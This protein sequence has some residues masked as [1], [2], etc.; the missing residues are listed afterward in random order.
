[1]SLFLKKLQKNWAEGRYFCV[2][3]DTDAARLDLGVD[4]YEFNRKIIDQ[5]WDLV[6]AYKPNSAF[7]EAAGVA[8]YKA[9]QKTIQYI[10]EKAPEVLVIL[11]AK[12]GDIGNTSQAYARAAFEELQ[13][14]AVTLSPYMGQTSLQPFLDY[15]DKGCFI[16]CRTSNQGAG[17]FQDLDVGGEPLFI[18]VAKQVSKNWN[19]NRNCGLVVGATVSEALTKV[20]SVCPDLP[21]LVPGVGEQ[22]GSIKPETGLLINVSRAVIFSENPRR[23]LQEMAS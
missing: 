7:Y 17:E 5:T 21:I 10:H 2:G 19:T 23:S 1:M 20:R 15:A 6:A 9:L 3:L 13:A 4:Q 18:R 12:R 16:L 8:G 14:D 22:G 11:D